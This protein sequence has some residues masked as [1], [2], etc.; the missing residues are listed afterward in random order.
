[1]PEAGAFRIR[2]ERPRD[3]LAREILLDRAFGLERFAKT[4]EKFR[5]GR[6]PAEG[7]SFVAVSGGTIVGTLR[8]WLIEAGDRACLLLGPLAVDPRHRSAGIGSALIRHGLDRA[9]KLGHGSVLLVGDAP[10]YDRFGFTRTVAQPFHLPGPVDLDRFLGLEL[11]P[12]ALAGAKGRVVAAG[13]IVERGRGGAD[14]LA[15]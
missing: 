1:M 5:A 10:Y 8:F 15:A 9:C 7:L 13:L 4:C 3:S 2:E 6:C 11:T 14:R 12:G